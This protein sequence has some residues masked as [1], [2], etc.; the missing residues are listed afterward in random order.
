[1]L[2]KTCNKYHFNNYITFCCKI[3]LTISI[4]WRFRLGCF[5]FHVIINNDEKYL[6]VYSFF[7]YLRLFSQV[8]FP[9]LEVLGQ[10]VNKL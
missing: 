5:L 4:Y 6:Q 3:Y 10:K 7:Y 8:G 1:M 2:L 9:E